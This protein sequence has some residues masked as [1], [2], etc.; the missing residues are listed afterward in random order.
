MSPV[1]GL[2]AGEPPAPGEEGQVEFYMTMRFEG[3]SRMGDSFYFRG[4]PGK[5]GLSP[6]LGIFSPGRLSNLQ[7]L[8][9]GQ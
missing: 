9:P 1:R 5:K 2:P 7:S 6:F 3:Q 8:P 4:G